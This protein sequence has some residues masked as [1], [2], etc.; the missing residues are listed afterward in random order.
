[1]GKPQRERRSVQS[2]QSGKCSS[3]FSCADAAMGADLCFKKAR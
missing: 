1:M 3:T 2:R